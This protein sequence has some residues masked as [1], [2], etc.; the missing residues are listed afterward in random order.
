VYG[1]YP[2]GSENTATLGYVTNNPFGITTIA[3]QWADAFHTS[4][5]KLRESEKK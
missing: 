2:Q 5:R 3:K 1:G 4:I